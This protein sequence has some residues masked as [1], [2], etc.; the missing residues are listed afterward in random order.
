M[1]P[2]E[3]VR[4]WVESFNEGDAGKITAFYAQNA[5]NQQVANEPVEGKYAIR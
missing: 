4:L 1:Q 5:V 3:L 2:K